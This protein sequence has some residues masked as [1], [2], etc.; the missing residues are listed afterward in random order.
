MKKTFEKYKKVSWKINKILGSPEQISEKC[1]V[2]IWLIFLQSEKFPVIRILA[3][4][5]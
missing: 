4:Y 2:N 3:Y 5:N 1:V